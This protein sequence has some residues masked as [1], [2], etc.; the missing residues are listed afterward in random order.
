MIYI[1]IN[2]LLCVVLVLVFQE[3]IEWYIECISYCLMWDLLLLSHILLWDGDHHNQ[4]TEHLNHPQKFPHASLQPIPCLPL[5]TPCK[6]WSAFGHA[7]V[8]FPRISHKWNNMACMITY[9]SVWLLPLTVMFWDAF[10]LLC[11]A[12]AFPLLFCWVV[13][14]CMSVPQLVSSFYW[15]TFVLFPG[16]CWFFCFCF[17]LL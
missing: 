5:P 3:H 17:W 8:A 12:L 6:Y 2:I 10:I 15:W 4:H 1:L 16:C 7:S 11:E 13:F 14:Y 9:F